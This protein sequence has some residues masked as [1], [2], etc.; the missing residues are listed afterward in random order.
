MIQDDEGQFSS[1]ESSSG[2]DE[3][4]MIAANSC[5]EAAVAVPPVQASV[6]RSLLPAEGIMKRE[7]SEDGE[8]TAIGSETISQPP[9][10]F[11]SAPTAAPPRS[12]ITATCKDTKQDFSRVWIR[13]TAIVRRAARNR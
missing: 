9:Y 7:A 3:E 13:V 8:L 1:G 5:L 11:K 6:G 12:G 2:H 10:Q 4:A